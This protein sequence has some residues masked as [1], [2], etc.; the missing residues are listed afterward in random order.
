MIT[1]A[2]YVLY[3]LENGQTCIH[4]VGSSGIQ[5]LMDMGIKEVL[6][7]GSWSDVVF[8]IKTMAGL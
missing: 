3:L 7:Y 5:T 6:A 8:A 2:T 1:F 4:K